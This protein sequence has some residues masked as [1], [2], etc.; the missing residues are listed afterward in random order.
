MIYCP[1]YSPGVVCLF[2]WGMSI[3]ASYINKRMHQALMQHMC[4]A[5][6]HYIMHHEP[7]IYQNHLSHPLLIFSVESQKGFAKQCE[8]KPFYLSADSILPYLPSLISSY[9]SEA[10]KLKGDLSQRII[11]RYCKLVPQK[12]CEIC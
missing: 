12:L 2:P 3:W 9:L 1:A 6:D 8:I 4:H 10:V 11:V 5:F 7:R